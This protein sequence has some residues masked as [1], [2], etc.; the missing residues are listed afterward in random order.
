MRDLSKYKDVPEVMDSVPELFSLYP[1]KVCSLLIDFFE[2]SLRSKAE[3]Q[4]QAIQKFLS[5]VPKLKGI[6]DIW[7]VRK[8]I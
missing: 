6:R 8:L 5:G 4:K 2:V 1:S 7:K 3:V